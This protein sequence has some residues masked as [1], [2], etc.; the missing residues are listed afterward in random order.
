MNHSK[1]ETCF[2]HLVSD[3]E[4]PLAMATVIQVD[5][6][7]S[8][9]P[10]DKALVSNDGIVEGWIGGGCVQSALIKASRNA[11][12]SQRAVLIRLAPEGQWQ[13][14]NGIED[15]T[16]GCLSGGSLLIFI[17][18]IS[19]KPRLS[20][21]GH[22]PIALS[23]TSLAPQ[24]GFQV[25]VISP[26]IHQHKLPDDVLCLPDFSS[27]NFSNTRSDYCVI[28]TQGKYDKVALKAALNTNASYIAMIASKKKARALKEA[29]LAEGIEQCQIERISSPA[30][31]DINAETP[32][33]IAL[34]I[35]AELVKLRRLKPDLCDQNNNKNESNT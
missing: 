21:L 25:S 27:S 7:T 18:P 4:T 19:K 17:E 1:L 14:I 22:S 12:A 33:E 6:P 31:F 3:T 16:S 20:I 26:D 8:S 32:A 28:A 10:G 9:K 30:G 5:P 13:T 35:L 11:I 23:L 34:S 15:F 24:L 29:L 2:E